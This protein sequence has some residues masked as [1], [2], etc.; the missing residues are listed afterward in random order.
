MVKFWQAL[1]MEEWNPQ[2]DIN[3]FSPHITLAQLSE[4][5]TDELVANF[6]MQH[7]SISHQITPGIDSL[8][9][10]AKQDHTKISIQVDLPEG[11]AKP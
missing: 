7:S 1:R 6:V 10:H 9:F 4:D 8:F 11:L 3:S 5:V 2:A